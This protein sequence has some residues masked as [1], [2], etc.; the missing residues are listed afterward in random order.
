VELSTKRVFQANKEMC[1]ASCVGGRAGAPREE[2][3]TCF[4][5][6]RRLALLTHRWQAFLWHCRD[7]FS[8][9][10]L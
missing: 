7:S 4:W 2:A 8:G 1:A 10:L 9:L 3:T 6:C 5:T